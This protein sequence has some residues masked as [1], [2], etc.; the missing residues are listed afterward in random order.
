MLTSVPLPVAPRRRV[1]GGKLGGRLV[2]GGL[3][4]PA[5]IATTL[6]IPPDPRRLAKK[7]NVCDADMTVVFGDGTPAEFI[8][9]WLRDNCPASRS[10]TANGQRKFSTEELTADQTAVISATASADGTRIVVK[11]GAPV[12]DSVGDCVCQSSCRL[13]LSSRYQS[14]SPKLPAS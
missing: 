1:L 13:C 7:V 9:L 3:I 11:W 2:A 8:G 14:F 12:N 10:R 6:A 5:S 4:R